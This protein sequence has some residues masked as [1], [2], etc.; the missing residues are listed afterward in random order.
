VYLEEGVFGFRCDRSL[1]RC[2]NT[3]PVNSSGCSPQ[4]VLQSCQ[5]KVSRRS[6][7]PE[8]METLV[9]GQMEDVQGNP[10]RR[11]EHLASQ[12][13]QCLE[14][15]PPGRPFF[16]AA[17]NESPGSFATGCRAAAPRTMSRGKTISG[18]SLDL[19]CDA[20]LVGV[21]RH[22]MFPTSSATSKAPARSMATPTGRPNAAP[23]VLRK[24]VSMSIGGPEG[25][26]LANG[27]KI[28]SYGASN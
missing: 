28:T 9:Q 12:R 10:Q 23:P 2:H 3:Y 25:R 24:P 14:G 15:R 19:D 4:R 26:P 17:A 7:D 13:M 22:T 27:T 5:G 20:Y 21:T 6:Q 16:L 18:A 8:A 1:G 11:P